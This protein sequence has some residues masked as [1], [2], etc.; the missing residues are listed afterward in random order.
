VSRYVECGGLAA[1]L[2]SMTTLAD[3]ERSSASISDAV[4]QLDCLGCLRTL[5]SRRD[6]LELFLDAEDHANKL[7]ECQCLILYLPVRGFAGVS[8]CPRKTWKTAIINCCNLVLI[9]VIRT[10]ITR[11]DEIVVT[12]DRLTLGAI[13][14]FFSIRTV[15]L[16]F[17]CNYYF[18]YVFHL[19]KFVCLFFSFFVATGFPGE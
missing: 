4:L 1:L 5:L 18:V 12:F 3:M 13:F 11:I 8:V 2:D 7:V 14:V 16:T 15:P 9:E 17:W 6:A 10:R 19:I